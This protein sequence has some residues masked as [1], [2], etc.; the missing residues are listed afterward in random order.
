MQIDKEVAIEN[1]LETLLNKY[2]IQPS[3]EFQ[4][5]NKVNETGRTSLLPG[6]YL[7][8]TPLT[9]QLVPLLTWRLKRQFT[10][11]KKIVDNQVLENV[12]LLRF[13]SFTSND[14]SLRSLLYCEFD[15]VEYI[16]GHKIVSVNAVLDDEKVGNVIVCLDNG[17]LCSIEVS[18]Q[19]PQH[20]RILERHEIIAK[21]GAASDLVVDSQIPQSSIYSFIDG[22]E[23]Q[24]K[25][26]DM[27]LFDY[28][29]EDIDHIR[30]AF[31][32]IKFPSLI[33]QWS[34]QHQRLTNLVA[35][36]FSSEKN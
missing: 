18:T 17:I 14:Q 23:E 30:A 16:T 32:V 12:C 31:E 13:C 24:F 25:D 36:A 2:G 5:G 10:E 8:D 26:Y 6:W 15:L 11:L 27:E 4:L 20:T 28:E 22:K 33:G 35:Q 7:M 29:K 21:R 1:G 9:P 3:F 19:L 34:L